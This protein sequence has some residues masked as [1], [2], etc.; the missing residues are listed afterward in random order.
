MKLVIDAMIV[1][2]PTVFKYNGSI[3][4]KIKKQTYLEF[5]GAV[6]CSVCNNFFCI[7][8]SIVPHLDRKKTKKDEVQ[9]NCKIYYKDCDQNICLDWFH[10]N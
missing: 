10:L 1:N 4:N 5:E 6:V 7:S 3:L 2:G 8:C 9:S